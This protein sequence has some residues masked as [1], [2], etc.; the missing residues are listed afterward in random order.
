MLTP[1]IADEIM[2]DFEQIKTLNEYREKQLDQIFGK[3]K[4]AEE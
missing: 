2:A 4:L 1:A 3:S